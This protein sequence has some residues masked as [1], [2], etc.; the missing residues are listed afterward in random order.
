MLAPGCEALERMRSDEAAW[1]DAEHQPTLRARLLWA[2]QYD[3]RSEDLPLLRHLLQWETQDARRAWKVG[4]SPEHGR[5]IHLLALGRKAEDVWQL[6]EALTVLTAWPV[7]HV[8]TWTGFDH[9]L[10]AAG[11]DA[12]LAEVRGSDRPERDEIL[13][14]IRT[15]DYWRNELE[16]SLWVG[17][18]ITY[19]ADPEPELGEP[20]EGIRRALV[21]GDIP[22]ARMMLDEWMT[23]RVEDTYTLHVLIDVYT[24]LGDQRAAADAAWRRAA[25]PDPGT[26]VFWAYCEVAKREHAAGDGEAAWRALQVARAA[27]EKSPDWRESTPGQVLAAETFVLA[28]ALNPADPLARV[29]LTGADV[30]ARQLSYIGSSV[31]T[32]AMRGADKL[33]DERMRQRYEMRAPEQGRRPVGKARPIVGTRRR[34]WRRP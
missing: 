3:W 20:Q 1:A 16:P 13:R 22:L 32:E 4:G 28:A 31:R 27:L 18:G 17:P 5:A 29:V 14:R 12:V 9:Y 24:D 25:L 26:Q 11:T 7:P 6:F 19:P 15:D 34:W 2:I 23:G 8:A 10:A 21:V 33:G 30:L